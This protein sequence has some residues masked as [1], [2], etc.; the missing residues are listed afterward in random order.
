MSKCSLF[1]LQIEFIC[2]FWK[3]FTQPQGLET[4][5]LLNHIVMCYRVFIKAQ[6]GGLT[7]EGVF[8]HF[9]IASS[10]PSQTFNIASLFL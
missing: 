4:K 9:L 8:K 5:P 6:I 1:Q 2:F 3:S 10:L 7:F